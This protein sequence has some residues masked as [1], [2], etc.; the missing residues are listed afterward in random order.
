MS[1]CVYYNK[2]TIQE[3]LTNQRLQKMV[4]IRL[5]FTVA[6]NTL[7]IKLLG[8]GSLK[9]A[10]L[11][12]AASS[13]ASDLL[14]IISHQIS[15]KLCSP[16]AFSCGSIIGIACSYFSNIPIVSYKTLAYTVSPLIAYIPVAYL[17]IGDC[18]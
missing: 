2:K 11:I 4:G 6:I 10:V 12:G 5:I 8:G 16:I 14:H 7:A 15:D 17:L 18:L 3:N 13:L 1:T 9:Q